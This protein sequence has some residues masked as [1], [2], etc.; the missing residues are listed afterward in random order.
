MIEKEIV[1]GRCKAMVRGEGSWPHFNQCQRK[2]DGVTGYCKQHNPVNVEAAKVKR[3]KQWESEWQARNKKWD[4]D[5]RIVAAGKMAPFLVAAL[6]RAQYHLEA[7]E[8]L[9]AQAVIRTAIEDWN[10]GDSK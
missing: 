2:H 7:Q 8:Y 4:D 1:P 9:D 10:N 6:K 3:Q 5:R